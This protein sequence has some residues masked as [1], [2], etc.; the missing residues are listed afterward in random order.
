MLLDKVK[1]WSDWI[2]TYF[3]LKHDAAYALKVT[4][5][6]QI[7]YCLPPLNLSKSQCD[8]LMRPILKSAL[9][10]AGYNRNF[11][12]EVLHGPTSLL[13]ADIHHPYM[14][15]LIA[16]LDI[17]LQHGGQ[18]TITGHLL[19]G[20]LETTKLELGRPRPLFGQDFSSFGKL[21][22]KSWIRGVWEEIATIGTDIR[23]EEHSKS[24]ALQG[25]A[26]RFLIEAFAASGYQNKQLR[27]LN[28][29]RIRLHAITL[30]GITTGDGRHLLEGIFDGTNPM[31][32][33]SP[34]TYPQQGQLPPAAWRLWKAALKKALQVGHDG[35]LAVPLGRWISRE[36]D[37]TWPSWYNPTTSFIYLRQSAQPALIRCFRI[38]PGFAH[39]FRH[40]VANGTAKHPPPPDK[41][42][43]LRVAY[44]RQSPTND[45]LG[46]AY[47]GS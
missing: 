4:V 14:T 26:D 29:C 15:Q 33:A 27:T 13:G 22:T 42:P 43:R 9:P 3:L 16:H 8:R 32:D 19:T 20:N 45:R 30:A 5:L 28:C 39:G 2:R 44:R 25:H 46:P 6:K 41:R 36:G 7:D 37:R 47:G 12:K 11:P 1:K 31:L 18:E 10:K 35:R 40:Y 38:T 17:L 23:L 34:H 24:L 21:A